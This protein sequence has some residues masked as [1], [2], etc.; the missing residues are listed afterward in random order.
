MSAQLTFWVSRE[1][2][3]SLWTWNL[4][5]SARVF[6]SLSVI[7]HV[8]THEVGAARERTSAPSSP[9]GSWECCDLWRL[10]NVFPNS[11]WAP[12]PHGVISIPAVGWD[13]YRQEWPTCTILR[14]ETN[15]CHPDFHNDLKKA[16]K[17]G[18]LSSHNVFYFRSPKERAV[19]ESLAR[20]SLLPPVAIC[21]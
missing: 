11:R 17:N 16:N 3:L 21:C 9:W 1:S 18:L 4:T 12:D 10:L 5:D 2:S 7:A 20:F 13:S 19:L 8:C 6:L 15:K 14:S